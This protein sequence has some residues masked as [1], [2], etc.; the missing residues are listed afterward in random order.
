MNV[1]ARFYLP[2]RMYYDKFLKTNQG[3]Q[4]FLEK[5]FV[6]HE[7]H[8]GQIVKNLCRRLLSG[9]VNV[10]QSAEAFDGGEGLPRLRIP[11]LGLKMMSN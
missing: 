11:Q 9:L 5:L 8:R 10:R 7:E 3:K 1:R 4:L 6:R 2:P